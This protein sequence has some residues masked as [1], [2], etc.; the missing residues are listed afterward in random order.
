MNKLSNMKQI[1]VTGACGGIGKSLVY[2]LVSKGFLVW[3]VDYNENMLDETFNH[4]NIIKYVCDL[5]DENSIVEMIKFIVSS[6]GPIDGLCH[7]A[8]FDKL[9]PLFLN[10]RNDI[11]S[12]M[13]IHVYAA[14]D[15]CKMLAKKGNANPGCSI[16]LISSL[17]AHE[18]AR[19]HTAYAAAKGAIE[20]FLAPASSELVEKGIRLNVVVLGAIN[21]KMTMGY[22]DKMDESQREE[23][24]RGYPL[25]FGGPENVTGFISFLLTDD[26]KWMTGQKYI[27]DGG[28]LI[29]K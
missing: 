8:G 29:R 27:L 12:L 4:S 14:M 1:I 9:S 22:V 11:E 19:G 16:V 5:N 17:S 25:G 15:L 10:K 18:G 21:T 2:N 24:E 26:A 3:A 28:H 6:K 23:F 13:K 7:C 20:G